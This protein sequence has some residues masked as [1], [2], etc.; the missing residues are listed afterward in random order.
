MFSTGYPEPVEGFEDLYGYDVSTGSTHRLNT[1][2]VEESLERGHDLA[3]P[4]EQ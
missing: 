4:V 1:A 2:T 3:M